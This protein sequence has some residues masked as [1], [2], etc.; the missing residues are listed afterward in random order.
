MLTAVIGD[1]SSHLGCTV[2]LKDSVTAICFVAMGTSLPGKWV[3]LS[4]IKVAVK[5]GRMFIMWN[6]LNVTILCRNITI[7]PF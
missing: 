2:G 6:L 5:S 7:N 3:I 4:Q 1:V